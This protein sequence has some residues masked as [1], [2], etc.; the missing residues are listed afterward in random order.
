MSEH[1]LVGGSAPR[2]PSDL[3]AYLEELNIES[4]TFEHPAVFTVEEAKAHR[5]SLE[6]AFT[7]NLFV[8]D[9]KGVMWL[10]VALEDRV[11]DLRALAESLG[12]KRFS[13]GSPERLMK[14]LGVIPG[15]VTPFGVFNDVTGAVQVALDKGLRAFDLWNFH[16]L[17]NGMTTTIGPA[18]MIRFLES[19]RHPPRWVDIGVSSSGDVQD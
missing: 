9:K 11:V 18:D 6:G 7:K 14:Y 8:R 5:G 4:A 1:L 2:R 13:F 15:A 12:H 10:I 3:L 16:P 17:D 19:V